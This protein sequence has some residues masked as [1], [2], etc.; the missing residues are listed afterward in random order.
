MEILCENELHAINGGGK[1]SDIIKDIGGSI[2]NAING[3]VSA[4]VDMAKTCYNAGH[5]VG[6]YFFN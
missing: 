1:L 4:T 6:D 5:R 3:F 2:P